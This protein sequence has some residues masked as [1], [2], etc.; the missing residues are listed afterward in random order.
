MTK[1]L[2][3]GAPSATRRTTRIAGRASALALITAASLGAGALPALAQGAAELEEIVVTARF[4]EENIQ[5]TPIAITALSADDLEVRSMDNVEDVGLSIPNAY[6]RENVGN[7]GPTGTIGLRGVSQY[8]FSYAFEPA[9]GVYIDDVYHGTLTGSFMDLVD[10]ERL[11]VLRGPQ[12]TLFGKN[13]LG[14]A[15]RLV[16]RKPEGDNTGRVEATYGSWDRLDLKGVAD[17][18]LVE[19]HVFARIVG[20]SKNQ[21]G[22]AHY[23]DFACQMQANGTPELAGNMVPTVDFRGKDNCY[24]GSLGGRQ[25]DAGRVMLRIVGN[26]SLEVNI[27]GDFTK[28]KD[29]P[30]PMTLLTHHG[31]LFDSGYSAGVI[32]PAFGVSYTDDDR[33][34]TGDPYTNYSNYADPLEGQSYDPLART[35]TWGLSGTVDYDVAENVHAKAIVAYRTYDSDWSSDTDLTPFP[36]QGTYQIQEHEQWQAELQLTGDALDSALEWTLGAFYYDSNSRAYNT[37]EFGAFD[38]SGLLL[39]FVADD[40][41]TT[42]NKS[43][44]LHLVYH[45]TDRL[46]VSGGV[47]YTDEKKT[48]IFDH[49]PGLAVTEAAFKGSRWDWKASADYQL[50][51]QVFVYAQAATGF[52]SA[53]FTPRIFTIGQLQPLPEEEVTTY[54]AGAKFDLLDRRLRINT[55]LF[56]SDY[57]PRIIQLGG[58]VQCD[59]VDDPNPTPYFL[60]GGDCPAGTALAGSPGLNWFYYGNA[61]GKIKGAEL[62]LTANPIANLAVN[63][64]FGYNK[65]HNAEKDPT[66]PAYRDPSA[67][68]QPK[69]NMSGGVQYAFEVDGAGS[70]ITPR[71]DWFFQSHGTNGA[72]N[73]PNTCPEECVPSYNIFN[74]RITYDNVE[75]NFS[76]AFAVT[77]LFDK[78]YWQQLGAAVTAAGGV[79]NARTGV[80]SRPRE[81]SVTATKRF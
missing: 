42:N 32:M 51:D 38:Y 68:L 28:S 76:V 52:R 44:F 62:E 30:G 16:S 26:D 78:F 17:F 8:D 48:N 64:S 14:G 66:S 63:F 37:T 15:I 59:A 35:K 60:Q 72:A 18:S 4:R 5:T 1:I 55:A 81:W 53:G 73:M 50:T 74:G 12:G 75:Q 21:D 9:V 31:G 54:E 77:N 20:V 29:E 67:L 2:V 47:R 7:Y 70:T 3:S 49:Q 11:E 58:V 71:L 46:S 10:L 45:L 36:I 79:P 43:G 39:N 25:S 61:P 80:P 69:Y 57:D 22:Y 33:F 56:Q 19:D 41:Y 6:F 40:Y 23:V 24:L 65:Y 13:S 34:V 27:T